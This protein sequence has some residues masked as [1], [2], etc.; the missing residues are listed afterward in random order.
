MPHD[1]AAALLPERWEPELWYGV[2][3][4]CDH[5]DEEAPTDEELTALLAAELA[6]GASDPYRQVAASCT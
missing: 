5:R 2:R 3:V 6:A 1:L 4:F